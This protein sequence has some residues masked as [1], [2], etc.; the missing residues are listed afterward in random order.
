MPM[1]HNGSRKQTVAADNIGGKGKVIR[2]SHKISPGYLLS[3]RY[4]WGLRNERTLK[5]QNLKLQ[6][7]LS[8]I[9]RYQELLGGRQKWLVRSTNG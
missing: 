7:E 4:S 6:S 9:K 8:K 2:C 5:A 1:L 3:L